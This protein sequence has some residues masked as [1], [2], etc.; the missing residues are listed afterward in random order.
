MPLREQIHSDRGIFMAKSLMQKLFGTKQE[1]DIKRLTPIVSQVNALHDWAHALADDEFPKVTMQLKQRLAEGEPLEALLPQAFALAREA[2]DR[3]LHER[4]YDEQIMGAAVLHQGT[5]LEMKTGEGKTLTCVPAAYLNA[6]EGKGVHIVTVNDYLAKRDSEWM[7]PIY[8]F[9]G[10]SVGVIVSDLD[11][12][13]RKQA[14]G[15]DITYGTN[16]EFG[17]DYLRDNMKWDARDKIQV[18]HHYAIIDEIDSIL[19]DE[20]RTPL[21]ISGQAADD[22]LKIRAA[23]KIVKSL[24]ECAKDP[25]TG[26]YPED[27]EG[28]FQVDEKQKRVTFTNQGLNHIE[29]LLQRNSVIAGF[30]Q[31]VFPAR[32][33]KQLIRNQ[34]VA[35]TRNSQIYR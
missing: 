29:E 32:Y 6:L 3:V 5:I 25:E 2:S 17:F 8:R 13:A 15:C 24:T 11:N 31:A 1:K 23:S 26:E 16:N 20:A 35:V 14:Y 34:P 28:D 7:G 18:Q 22:T 27:A 9:L 21:I 30:Q 10:L 4:H 12:E 33:L 19:I